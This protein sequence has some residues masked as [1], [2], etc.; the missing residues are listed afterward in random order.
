MPDY[1][2]C[3]RCRLNKC[4]TVGMNPRKVCVIK[5]DEGKV[6]AFVQRIKQQ[7]PKDADLDSAPE[8]KQLLDLIMMKHLLEVEQKVCRIRNSRTRIP[9]SFYD[10]CNSFTEPPNA[11]PAANFEKTNRL[12]PFIAKPP[13]LAMDLLFVFEIV[14]SFPSF[15]QLIIND[16]IA[17]CSNIAMPLVVLSKSFYSQSVQQNS[18]VICDPSSGV[19]AI[20]TITN[21]CFNE[22]SVIMKMGDQLLF[23]AVQPFSRLKLSTEEFVLVRAIVYSVTPGL[24][25]HGQKLLFTEAEK[26]SSLLMRNL[27]M[28]YG[29]APG[30]L[31]Y[32]ELMGMIECLFNTGANLRQLLTYFAIVY[33]QKFGQLFRPV[34][35]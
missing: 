8:Q 12:G 15:E 30:A 9:E 33:D 23:K 10:Q 16:K 17:L 19:I 32:V 1:A 7:S 11:P 13:Y 21:S 22:D 4:L 5:I 27:Q 3:K 28:N 25:D 29:P 20:N 34:L 31:R 2:V 6:R 24:S 26:Y 14:K 35:A 18:D